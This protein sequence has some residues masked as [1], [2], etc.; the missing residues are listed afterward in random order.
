MVQ[1][2]SIDSG[3]HVPSRERSVSVFCAEGSVG[4]TNDLRV[5][6]AGFDPTAASQLYTSAICTRQVQPADVEPSRHPAPSL[7]RPAVPHL[8]TTLSIQGRRSA[9]LARFVACRVDLLGCRGCRLH[10]GARPRSPDLS[11]CAA[12]DVVRFRDRARRSTGRGWESLDFPAGWP[13]LE[14][15]HP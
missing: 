1:L 10:R 8:R 14:A 7:L 4:K 3:I 11:R 5:A 9:R 12:G 15:A 13:V 2:Y 6:E